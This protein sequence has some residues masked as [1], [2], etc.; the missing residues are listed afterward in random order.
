M[1]SNEGFL[2]PESVNLSNLQNER[3]SDLLPDIHTGLDMNMEAFTRRYV[4]EICPPC[5]VEKCPRMDG[6]C[7]VEG[8]TVPECGLT[9]ERFKFRDT[10]GRSKPIT[11]LRM[12][13]D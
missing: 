6:V 4:E 7:Y 1:I 3:T 9:G 8:C 12:H 11:P 5:T 2:V 10:G 13:L